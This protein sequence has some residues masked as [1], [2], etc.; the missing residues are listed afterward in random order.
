M[1]RA[2]SGPGSAFSQ[3]GLNLGERV[4]AVAP[5]RAASCR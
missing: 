2:V 5:L 3:D 4:A 1:T